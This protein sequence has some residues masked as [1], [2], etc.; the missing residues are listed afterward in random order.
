MDPGRV[1]PGVLA[2]AQEALGQIPPF[3]FALRR[4][5][6]FPMT[7]Y[8]APEPPDP[9]IAMTTALVRAYPEFPPYGGEHTDV[10]PHLTV[11]HG[12]AEHAAVAA[13][14]LEARLRAAGS[15]EAR[16]TSVVLLENST[17]KWKELHAFHLQQPSAAPA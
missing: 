2:S 3:D 12:D 1:T 4:V 17:G 7:T 9:F 11:A 8:L 13:S 14:E 16:C 10:I 15:V 6:R 5:G